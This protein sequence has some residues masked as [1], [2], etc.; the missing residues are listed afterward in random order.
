[1]FIKNKIN[2][3]KMVS[4]LQGHHQVKY[5]VFESSGGEHSSRMPHTIPYG[6]PYECSS[7]LLS[8]T[9]YLT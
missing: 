5:K 3:T 2:L 4:A 7:P 1:M 6:T 8:K 9:L